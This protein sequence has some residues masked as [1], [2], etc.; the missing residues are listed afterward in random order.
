MKPKKQKQPLTSSDKPVAV[1]NSEPVSSPLPPHGM[2]ALR[3]CWKG[4]VATCL[5]FVVV[6][7]A[8]L[9]RFPY[10]GDNFVPRLES[11]YL[12][13]HG[14]LGIPYKD[15]ARITGLDAPKGQYFFSNDKKQKFYSKYGIFYTIAFLPP[16]LAEMRVNPAF[17]INNQPESFYFKL[18]LYQILLGVFTVF[19][20]F[21]L[22]CYFS[23]SQWLCA[24]FT[25]ATI[26][27]TFLWHYMRIPALEIYQLLAFSG[28]CFH[29]FVFMRRRSEGDNTIQCWM[30]LLASTAWSGSLVLMKSSFVVLGFAFSV[31]PFFIDSSK[32]TI[33]LRPVMS[34]LHHW[35]YYLLML[36]I[37]WAI[38][39]AVLLVSN[40]VR[41]ESALD[42][43]Y[44]Q[45]L[46]G[47]GTPQTKFGLTFFW[48]HTKGFLLNIKNNEFN[49]FHA[50]PYALVG[51]FSLIPFF[52]YR[53]LDAIMILA[54]TLPG[55]YLLLVYNM[56]D[57]QWCYGPRYFIFYAMLLAFPFLWTFDWL[58]TKTHKMLKPV[59][60][61]GCLIPVLYWATGQFYVNSVHYFVTYQM[62][63]V[64]TSTKH[65]GIERYRK[66]STRVSFCRDLFRYGMGWDK[67]YPLEA[68]RPHIRPEQKQAFL[69]YKAM[70]DHFAQSNFYFYSPNKTPNK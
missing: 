50:Y 16:V 35:K 54:A 41:F 13:K 52:R 39:F 44:M 38:V 36:V 64:L 29:A 45:W 12:A 57:G 3:A 20:L 15:R 26:Y 40:A 53:R 11:I 1:R 7:V 17:D 14:E 69:E 24:G 68:L 8:T 61:M 63:G 59:L 22:A 51:V 4:L 62:G 66:E 18:G 48:G 42:S 60:L 37:P 67:Y 19:Y 9:P 65:P 47:D 32:H 28:A 25:V 58:L 33:L 55:I 21:R 43:G 27:S 2:L 23:S 10:P 34:F 49:M 6:A 30:H 70:I 5:F 56:A 46:A 31:L